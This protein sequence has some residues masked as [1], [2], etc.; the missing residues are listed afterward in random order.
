MAHHRSFSP[1][2]RPDHYEFNSRGKAV[3]LYRRPAEDTSNLLFS[4]DVWR[5]SQ[6]GGLPALTSLLYHPVVA[7]VSRRDPGANTRRDSHDSDQR[8]IW[9]RWRRSSA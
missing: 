8:S 4:E 7:D 1:A 5:P 9:Q 6:L 2:S 3:S